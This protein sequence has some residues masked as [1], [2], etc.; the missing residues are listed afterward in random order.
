[1]FENR[2]RQ[3]IGVLLKPHAVDVDIDPHPYGFPD[4]ALG[5]FGVEVKFSLN[6]TWRSVANSVFER[7]R[8]QTVKHI[9]VVFGKMG[10]KPQVRWGKYEDCVMHVRTSHVPRFEVDIDA[11]ESLFKKFGIDYQTF[12]QLP[13]VERMKYVREYARSR[14]KP[15]DRL[16]WLDEKSDGERSVP[17]TVRLYSNLSREEK[18]QIRAEAALLCPRIV[19]AGSGG[20]NRGLKYTD[21]FLYMLTYRGVYATRDAFSAGSVAGKERGGNY[22]QRALADLKEEM[23]EAANSLEPALFEEY[24]GREVP[25]EKRIRE[26]LRMADQYAKETKAGWKPSESLFLKIP[27]T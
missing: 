12:S 27:K 24:W 15:G 1:V 16:W 5:E 23:I 26:W 2:V 11:K 8:E 20:N 13:E 22:V 17:L 6:D 4:I 9:Y 3:E 21:A 7:F 18:R 10:G 14:M 25:P 19:G